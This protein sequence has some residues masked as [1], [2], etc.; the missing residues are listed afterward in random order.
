MQIAPI[1]TAVRESFESGRHGDV[2]GKPG[3]GRT[4]RAIGRGMGRV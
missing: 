2:E 3:Q 1:A 4:T